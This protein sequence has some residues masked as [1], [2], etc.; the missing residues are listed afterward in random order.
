MRLVNRDARSGRIGALRAVSG[1]FSYFNDDPANV[2]N[3]AE[4][5]GG[6]LMDIGC[7]PILGARLLFAEEPRRVIA[8]LD[9]D[10]RFGTDRLGSAILDFPS[11][12]AVFSCATQLVPWQRIQAFGTRGRVELEIP[13]NAPNDRPC[14][15]LVDDGSDLFG[16]GVEVQSL[17]TCD[18]YTIQA[19]RF[20]EAIRGRAEPSLALEESI[21]NMQ[22]IDAL[23]S[24]RGP[25]DVARARGAPLRGG[26]LF[27]RDDTSALAR[28][29][30][31]VRPGKNP[32]RR[33]G[34]TRLRFTAAAASRAVGVTVS[35]GERSVW[36]DCSARLAVTVDCRLS[37]AT[38]V[39]TPTRM[40]PCAPPRRRPAGPGQVAQDRRRELG[41]RACRR[42]RAC[43]PRAGWP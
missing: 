34:R 42:C 28:A 23:P 25:G 10:P 27:W 33:E 11:G 9:R 31:M 12:Q 15:L 14:R 13:F 38:A 41:G 43:A 18:Q 22:V 20:A 37:T 16:R 2:R 32:E 19:E 6:A 17:D 36:R 39:H 40:S 30:G 4:W 24:T 29:S 35:V 26:A 1:H 7:Y 21:R 5:G 3:V 8:L